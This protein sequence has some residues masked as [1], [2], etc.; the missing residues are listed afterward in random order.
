[1]ERLLLACKFQLIVCF[2]NRDNNVRVPLLLLSV[3]LVVQLTSL[4]LSVSLGLELDLLLVGPWGQSGLDELLSLGGGNSGQGL[5]SEGVGYWLALLTLLLLPEVHGLEASSSANGL[6]GE[7]TLGVVLSAVDGVTVFLGLA[8]IMRVLTIGLHCRI[9]KRQQD[10]SD[11]AE[12]GL[13]VG[14]RWEV[15]AYRIRTF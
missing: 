14:G 7:R 6:V 15:E 1:M 13:V 3:L 10:S 9:K 2:E 11:G 8:C 12:L 4:L 5:L